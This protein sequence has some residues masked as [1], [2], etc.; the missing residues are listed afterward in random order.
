VA[1]KSGK[2]I[3]A[4][5][6][7][8]PAGKPFA[9]TFRVPHK[10]FQIPGMGQ[11]LTAETLL[12]AVGIR[13]EEVESWRREGVSH[14]SMNGSISDLGQPLPPPRQVVT[15]LTIHVNLKPPPRAVAVPEDREPTQ[16]VAP[17]ENLAPLETGEP[18][19]AV[20]APETGEPA[21][22][23][24]PPEIGEPGIPEEKWQELEA[25]WKAIEG[26]EATVDTLRIRLEGLQTEMET[27]SKKTLAME[28]KIHA[29]SADVARWNKA[30]S[31]VHYAIPKVRE[32]VHRAT[33]ATGTPERKRLE[34]FFKNDTRPDIPIAQ[35]D[36]LREELENLLKDRQVLSAHGVMVSQECENIS[37][38]VQTALETLQS[39]ADANA[40][41][42]ARAARA[43]GKFF[44]D[45]RRLSGAE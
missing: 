45:V 12:K 3:I 38:E 8:K 34:E 26:L 40:R 2:D 35:A 31:R 43:Q 33:W 4:E 19:Q 6:W 25:R 18:A 29:L 13:A 37:A 1:L 42:N 22:V 41:K 20:A 30:K 23:I 27:S 39:N 44:K 9:L 7:F 32:F 17:P 16:A 11:R 10:S 5:V 28:E 24:A 14:S 21:Q 36:K 15:H